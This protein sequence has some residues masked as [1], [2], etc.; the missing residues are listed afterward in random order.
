M[1]L[2]NGSLMLYLG[3]IVD[4]FKDSLTSH[5]QCRTACIY[6]RDHPMTIDVIST[7]PSA[8]Q[9]FRLKYCTGIDGRAINRWSDS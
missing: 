9:L 4:P 2:N 6:T 8:V 7:I 5:V 3:F 1:T